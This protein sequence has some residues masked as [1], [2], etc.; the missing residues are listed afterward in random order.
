MIP[1][2]LQIE[3]NLITGEVSDIITKYKVWIE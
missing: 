3:R 2:E 1:R